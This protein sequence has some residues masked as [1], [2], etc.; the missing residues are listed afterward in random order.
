MFLAVAVVA[1]GCGSVGT[2]A[3]VSPGIKTMEARAQEAGLLILAKGK[4][5]GQPC[6]ALFGPAEGDLI[7]A[8]DGPARSKSVKNGLVSI[9]AG[10]RLMIFN[11]TPLLYGLLSPMNNIS[12]E[13]VD[14]IVIPGMGLA[15]ARQ[16]ATAIH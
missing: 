14:Y 1:A 9:G 4:I 11:N 5:E 12:L 15:E 13:K 7:I 3:S 6:I 8:L 16:K 2:E 10:G